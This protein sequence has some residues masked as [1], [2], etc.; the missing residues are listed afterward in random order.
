MKS[1]SKYYFILF[2]LISTTFANP[3][4]APPNPNIETEQDKETP[5]WVYIA[6]GAA[7]GVAVGVAAIVAL[8]VLG[9]GT[10]GVAAGS[11]AAGTQA[12]IGNVVA[13]SLFATAQSI[14]ATMGVATVATGAAAGGVVGA[15]GGA[16]A[17][18]VK[19]S[20]GKDKICD[21]NG[22]EIVKKEGDGKKKT[23]KKNKNEKNS[24]KEK[25][26]FWNGW[27]QEK[28]LKSTIVQKNF[29]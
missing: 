28:N 1:Q 4:K 11:V 18:Q 8:P 9:F 17:S 15:G 7:V 27:W 6:G 26:G 22:N 19:G 20:K 25:N 2:L 3:C 16:I 13:G 21:E 10:A 5:T 14:G 12:A 23:E 24:K 29:N